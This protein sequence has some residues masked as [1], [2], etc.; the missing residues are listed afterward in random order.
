[1]TDEGFA[2]ANLMT[3]SRFDFLDMCSTGGQ[4]SNVTHMRP[5]WVTPGL[6]VHPRHDRGIK[7]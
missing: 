3:V 7:L 2:G 5:A 1:M 6:E 4:G